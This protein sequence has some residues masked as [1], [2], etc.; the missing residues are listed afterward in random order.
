MDYYI[1]F[2][3]T[4]LFGIIYQY[5]F[6]T[7]TYKKLLNGNNFV[8]VNDTFLKEYWDRSYFLLLYYIFYISPS[9]FYCLLLVNMLLYKEG[10][11]DYYNF[12]Y[13]YTITI[14]CI[15]NLYFAFIC[16]RKKHIQMIEVREYNE[17]CIIC[18]QINNKFVL[19]SCGHIFHEEC[20]REWIKIKEICPLCRE[21]LV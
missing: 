13:Y 15:I 17:E 12:F 20:L 9:T 11:N 8:N 2:Y 14:F 5:S 10:K 19:I 7:Y 1:G 16:H 6:L 3:I 21:N 4:F 18:Y